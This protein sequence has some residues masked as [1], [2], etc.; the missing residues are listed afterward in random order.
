MLPL[1]KQ[2]PSRYI[3]Q[4]DEPATQAGTVRAPSP[5]INA[6]LGR[7][8]LARESD[9][10]EG[11]EAKLARDLT[12]PSWTVRVEATQR[13]GKIGK[14][15]P[16]ALLLVALSDQKDSVRAAAARALG[17]NP[18][19]AAISALVKALEDAVWVVRAEAALA[20]GTME[21]LAPLEPLLVATHDPDAAVRAAAITALGELGAASARELL[22]A[23]LQDDDWSVREAATLALAN[24]DEQA[25]L[26]PRHTLNRHLNGD[27]VQPQATETDLPQLSAPDSTSSLPPSA[28]F[29]RWL[30]RI[31]AFQEQLTASEELADPADAPARTETTSASRSSASSKRLH[32][33]TVLR[34]WP[35]KLTHLAKG[36][37]IALLIV[38]LLI[39]WFVIA[40]RPSTPQRKVGS[41]A[42]TIYHG[43]MSSV[44]KAVWAPDGQTIASADTRGTVSIWQANTGHTLLTYPQRGTAL[45]LIWNSSSTLLVAYGE[46]NRSLQV[47]ELTIG[48]TPPVQMI[49]Q[50]TNLP[51]VPSVA[52]WS[53]NQQTLAFDTGDGSV[54][55]WNV[56]ANLN[57]ATFQE[58]HTR[59]AELLWSPDTPVLAMLSTTGQLQVWDI[60]TWQNI[61][62]LA[63]N[64]SATSAIWI[65]SSHDGG[66]MFF[67]TPDGTIMKWHYGQGSQTVTP[68][69]TTQ[70]YNAANIN[71]LTLSDIALSPDGIQLLLATSDGSVQARDAI[72]GN[73]I[74]L[75]Q[76]HSAP[77]NDIEWSLDSRHIAT[78]S[79]DTTAQ[80]W[81]E[82]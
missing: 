18:R 6:I 30:E 57:L 72:S 69:L 19:P 28:S 70:T 29:A 45:A 27:P 61:A 75:Y 5:A 21:E 76:G 3:Q 32:H 64:Q 15:A 7:L 40:T 59:C 67:V 1:G 23:A 80:I 13:L 4:S 20:L 41:G 53:V 62:S 31:E 68:F 54:E 73:L 22:N 38:G 11:N 52:A 50:R 36:L 81:Q 14:Q 63:N 37:L 56:S 49:F 35:L 26:P 42:F 12:D 51:G 43:H 24:L 39:A 60:Y 9:E 77:V 74:Y 71:G 8:G 33:A 34:K 10:P 65:S 48:T 47:Q 79:Q 55:V 2:P 58:P 25:A 17:R 16:L 82:P 78:A 66:S 44:T 46:P